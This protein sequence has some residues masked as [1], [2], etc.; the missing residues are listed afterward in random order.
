MKTFDLEGTFG[1]CWDVRRVRTRDHSRVGE[2]QVV[3]CRHGLIFA[4][5]STT[6]GAVA[7]C[8]T[9]VAQR[10]R[11]I[12]GVCVIE[13]G[14]GAASAIFGLPELISVQR[15]LQP[16]R[17]NRRQVEPAARAAGQKHRAG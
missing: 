7:D 6:L 14:R 15:V 4:V 3:I 10:L 12:D 8:G 2:D 16:R 9:G 17:V 13:D 5:D 1:H 11:E